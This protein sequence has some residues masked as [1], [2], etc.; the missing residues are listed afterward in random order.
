MSG[1][2]IFLCILGRSLQAG[3]KSFSSSSSDTAHKDAVCRAAGCSQL[4]AL[5]LLI[6]VGLPCCHLD[7]APGRSPLSPDLL[8]PRWSRASV[9]WAWVRGILRAFWGAQARTHVFQMDCADALP[10]TITSLAFPRHNGHEATYVDRLCP[11]WWLSMLELAL[12][13][14]FTS[15]NPTRVGRTLY[16]RESDSRWSPWLLRGP[17]SA[18]C[19][20]VI[21]SSKQRRYKGNDWG[22]KER[23][24]RLLFRRLII[25]ALLLFFS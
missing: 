14:L 5:L 15:V 13:L 6:Y 19:R 24:S 7:A 2:T 1:G 18:V 25:S 9:R 20:A 21:F 17:G 10:A 23:A 22:K 8:T 12:G 11:G 16:L 3:K 4:C